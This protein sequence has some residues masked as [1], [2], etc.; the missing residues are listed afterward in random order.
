LTILDE[1]DTIPPSASLNGIMQVF[2]E[3]I[4][5]QGSMIAS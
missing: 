4:A 3:F 1:V 2:E 5:T